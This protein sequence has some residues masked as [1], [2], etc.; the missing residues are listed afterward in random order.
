MLAVSQA[1]VN[2][3]LR[4]YGIPLSTKFCQISDSELDELIKIVKEHFPRSGYRVM[5]G[6]LLSMGYHIQ[7]CR[8]RA[9]ESLR[10]KSRCRRAGYEVSIASDN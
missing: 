9:R 7:E 6:I 5:H 1:I 2:R 3:R 4:D 8:M 10:T